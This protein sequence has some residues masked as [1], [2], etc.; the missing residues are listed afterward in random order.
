MK[1]IRAALRHN[2]DGGSLRGASTISQQVAKNLFLWSGRSW[3][4]KGAEAWFT[5]ALETLW[6][7]Q[8]ILEV[9]LNIVEWDDGVFGIAA[10]SEHHFGV[11]RPAYGSAG[12]P[13]GRRTAQPA[14]LERPAA[15]GA[16]PAAGPLDSPA[17]APTGWHSL[18][19][20]PRGPAGNVR[21]G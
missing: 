10:A 12:R 15:T 17:G 20:A 16:C 3:M 11:P 1:A 13:A 19:A 18:S 2:R 14:P 4:R 8:R 7:K 9:Y 6:P 21:H 5:L